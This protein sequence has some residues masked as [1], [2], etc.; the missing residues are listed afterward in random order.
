MIPHGGTAVADFHRT[1]LMPRRGPFLSAASDRASVYELPPAIGACTR[2]KSYFQFRRVDTG[3]EVCSVL[4]STLIGT[5]DSDGAVWARENLL[6]VVD[7]G[8][9]GA[10]AFSNC[11][12]RS[13]NLWKSRKLVAW[14]DSDWN[15]IE[16]ESISQY[17][18]RDK[19][20]RKRSLLIVIAFIGV[21]WWCPALSSCHPRVYF[22][23]VVNL[24]QC[25][26]SAI[27]R[28][29]ITVLHTFDGAIIYS[30]WKAEHRVSAYYRYDDDAEGWLPVLLL[31]VF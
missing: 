8:I 9:Y 24:A 19:R 25:W 1:W 13:L 30:R 2:R 22:I 17:K 12:K 23:R 28:R 26:Q 5:I 14:H 29:R 27:L 10:Y 20:G 4:L 11:M 18:E 3:A 21:R 15:Q 16:D 31:C 6:Y 7:P